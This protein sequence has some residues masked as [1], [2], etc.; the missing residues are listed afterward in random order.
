MFVEWT[1]EG[2]DHIWVRL[3]ECYFS[4]RPDTRGLLHLSFFPTP[5]YVL[6]EFCFAYHR[7]YLK[8]QKSS[9]GVRS[10]SF[11]SGKRS[12]LRTT[13]HQLPIQSCSLPQKNKVG[14][15][16]QGGCPRW[17]TSRYHKSSLIS[18]V[19][20]LEK[21]WQS[22]CTVYRKVLHPESPAQHVLSLCHSK[23]MFTLCERR[24]KPNAINPTY[25]V[26]I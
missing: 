26:V 21:C 20:W 12:T 3:L 19:Y 15:T 18:G 9:Q 13:S 24:A 2:V 16:W 7:R 22:V 1:N 25:K 10:T 6:T 11:S 5:S 4:W 8:H 23:W 14:C 17:Q